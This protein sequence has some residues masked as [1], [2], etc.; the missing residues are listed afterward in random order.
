MA[1]PLLRMR[2]GINRDSADRGWEKTD[3][4]LD[5]LESELDGRD[6]LVGDA[7]TV[8]DLTAAALFLRSS[9]PPRPS[10][11]FPEPLPAAL[12]SGA[13]RSRPAPGSSGCKRCTGAT[14]VSP[15]KSRRSIGPPPPLPD[16]VAFD[17]RCVP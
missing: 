10:T 4:A 17:R 16:V 2:F 6:Y 5:R 14:A 12:G 7:F 8:A 1:G 9:G 3:A 15:P 11:R 13:R